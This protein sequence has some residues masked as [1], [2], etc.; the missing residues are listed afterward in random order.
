MYGCN[1][2]SPFTNFTKVV[3]ELTGF[4]HEFVRIAPEGKEEYK[5]NVYSA[6]VFPYLKDESSGEGLGES[7]AI[8]RF[9]CNSTSKLYGSTAYE[10]ALI[11]EA[12]ER[13][14]HSLSFVLMKVLGSVLG[15]HPIKEEAFK[16][17]SKR[18]KDYFMTLNDLVKDKE[19]IVGDSLTLA[20]VY[21]AVSLNLFF[22]SALDA[23]FLKAIPHLAKYYKSIRSNSVIESHLGKARFIG[24]ALKPKLAQ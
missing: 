6:G 21:I 3:A 9:M 2:S 14:H 22:A 5:N 7:L 12:I 8:A 20:D 18:M 16:D 15:H 19:F 17:L 24:K 13:H 4:E 11:D 1:A 10:T 23:G